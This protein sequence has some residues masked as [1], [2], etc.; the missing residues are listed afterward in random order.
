MY[1]SFGQV[2]VVFESDF[3]TP[4]SSTVDY[5]IA[6]DCMNFAGE[7]VSEGNALDFVSFFVFY[8]INEFGLVEDICFFPGLGHISIAF[9]GSE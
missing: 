1:D 3:V 5:V 8:K 4:C 7:S 6:T 2:R 9:C